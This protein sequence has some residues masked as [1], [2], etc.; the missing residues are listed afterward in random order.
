MM[1]D[2]RRMMNGRGCPASDGLKPNPG[3]FLLRNRQFSGIIYELFCKNRLDAGVRSCF[4][5]QLNYPNL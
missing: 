1:N 5:V 4:A 2:D 3:G